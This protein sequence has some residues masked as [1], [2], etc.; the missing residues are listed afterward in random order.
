MLRRDMPSR[1]ARAADDDQFTLMFVQTLFHS[2]KLSTRSKGLLQL[3]QEGFLSINPDD[4]T[5]LGLTDG[6]AG[7]DLERTC[8]RDHEREDPRT[9]AGRPDL[10]PGAFRRRGQTARR[11]D[12]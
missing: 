2:G 10:V 4:A 6:G 5:R 3:Q 1:P 8:G 11:L 7:S 12:D 9:C